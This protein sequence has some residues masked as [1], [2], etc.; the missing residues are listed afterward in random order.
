MQGSSTRDQG[1]GDVA[2]EVGAISGKTVQGSSQS[3]K[4]VFCSVSKASDEILQGQLMKLRLR[5]CPAASPAAR[6]PARHRC[7]QGPSPH[8][9]RG[10]WLSQGKRMVFRILQGLGVTCAEMRPTRR[11]AS[12][13]SSKTSIRRSR[14][15]FLRKA[16]HCFPGPSPTQDPS[17]SHH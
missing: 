1:V 10:S 13:L 8:P 9:Q 16:P 17:S 12:L 5:E 15:I 14:F 2:S 6:L 7:Q 4:S 11:V 3:W